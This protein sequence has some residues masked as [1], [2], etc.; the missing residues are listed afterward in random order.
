M[1]PASEVLS[2][3][4][5][6]NA[7]ISAEIQRFSMDWYLWIYLTIS[8]IL[9]LRFGLYTTFLL[10]KTYTNRTIKFATSTLVLIDDHLVPHSFL[11]YIFINQKE[12][13]KGIFPK[14]ILLHEKA[15]VEQKHTLDILLI[16]LI[17]IL[18]WFNPF[19]YLYLKAIKLNH[20]FLADE[21]VI[22]HTSNIETYQSLLIR[23]IKKTQGFPFA[24]Q[25][26][27]SITKKR[28]IM[29]TKSKSSNRILLK[30]IALIPVF[31]L[32]L[33]FFSEK[34]IA[35]KEIVQSEKEKPVE[36]TS[37]SEAIQSKNT[38]AEEVRSLFNAPS[39]IDG[40]TAQQMQEYA[41]IINKY[42]SSTEEFWYTHFR[43]TIPD[44][45][46]KRLETIFIQMSREQQLQQNIAFFGSTGKPWPKIKPTPIQMESW[47]DEKMFGLW[48]DGKRV[49]NFILNDY[50]AND[51]SHVF[52][53]KLHKNAKNYGK[54]Y[55]QINLMTNEDFENNNKKRQATKGKF[56]MNY[57]TYVSKN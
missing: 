5:I 11:Q 19:L 29:M 22:Q 57:I 21:A 42:K 28:L 48:I 47:K 15:H 1:L 24:S 40:A 45:D 35:Q 16:E 36:N 50:Q 52:V 37:S 6:Q 27:F 10:T 41:S 23:N 49:D 13:E 25:L 8:A 53:S 12:F 26:N 17:I 32:S 34:T 44:T 18:F 56:S 54:H 9:F 43:N 3:I 14:E 20:E 39:T 7:N 31:L 33:Y 38:N 55:Y 51:F 2:Q 4:E 30:Q 46:K